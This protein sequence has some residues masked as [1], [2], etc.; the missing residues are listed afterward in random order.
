MVKKIRFDQLKEIDIPMF[1]NDISSSELCVNSFTDI[2]ELSRCYDT[3]LSSILDKHVPMTTKIMVVRPV[4]PWFNDDLKKLKAE[5]RKCERK[6]LQSGC[7]SDREIYYRTRDKYSAC[8]RKTKIS[9]YSDL[10][11]ECSDNSK[12]LFRVINALTKQ[13]S[14]ESL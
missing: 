2:D 13:K 12:K 10:I 7:S 8:L 1:K 3:T 9:Y 6:M 14:S 5:R 11:D 4:L